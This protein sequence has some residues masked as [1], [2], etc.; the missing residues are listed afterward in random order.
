M[1]E[2]PKYPKTKADELRAGVSIENRV[3]P[4]FVQRVRD[5]DG[6]AHMVRQKEDYTDLT[7]GGK[8]EGQESDLEGDE[9]DQV[10]FYRVDD[11]RT[12]ERRRRVRDSLVYE[13]IYVGGELVSQVSPLPQEICH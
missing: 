13:E 6:H 4:K 7:V 5:F 1:K 2:R 8:I 12:M 3:D 10:D 9:W 11:G